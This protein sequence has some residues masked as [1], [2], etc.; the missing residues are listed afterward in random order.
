MSLRVGCRKE[1]IPVLRVREEEEMAYFKHKELLNPPVARAAYSDRTAWLMA[2]MA[3]LAYVKF[4]A[5]AQRLR[6]LSEGLAEAAFELVRTFCSNGTQ[7]F[8]AK[9]D[10]DRMLILA[11][12]GTEKDD[13]YD[14]IADLNARFFTDE[15]GAKIHTGFYNAYKVVER[16]VSATVESLKGYALYVTGHSLGGALA[17]I[18]TRA[19][20]SDNLA[21]CYTFGS[22]KVGD[23][24]FGSD[25]KPPIYRVVNAYDPVPI[26][27]P[28]GAVELLYLLSSG[29]LR[30]FAKNFRGYKH[31]G[32][33]RFLTL[34]DDGFNGLKLISHSN[35][36][37]RI[38]GLWKHKKESIKYHAIVAYC[39]KLAHWALQRLHKQ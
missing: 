1:T 27:P 10:S 3:R 30:E 39:E 14:V 19:L 35:E 17:L 16:D 33:M 2:E 22:P 36:I 37:W 11:F 5:G 26:T 34:C 6:E 38:V 4:E 28:T 20:N 21:A 23:E 13:P 15:R 24:E 29:K 32:D 12:R 18:A 25:I 9:R 31:H 7:A 8:L